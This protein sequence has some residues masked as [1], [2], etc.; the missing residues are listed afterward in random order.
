CFVLSL[1]PTPRP[2]RFPYTTLFR[3]WFP[4]FSISADVYDIQLT[5]AISI[6]S[7]DNIV[8]ECYRAGA[9][10]NLI[11]RDANGLIQTVRNIYI[12]V[13]SEEH[14]SELQS[15]ENLVCRLLLEK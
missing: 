5:N 12:N 14:T 11:N 13:R 8:N 1:R 2:P 9:F 10:C 6:L 4:D 3:S 7:L 15:R